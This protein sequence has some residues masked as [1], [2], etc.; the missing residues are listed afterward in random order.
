MRYGSQH[1][2]KYKAS[3]QCVASADVTQGEVNAEGDA[4]FSAV[5][6]F[7][8]AKL[9]IL[10]LFRASLSAEAFKR[11]HTMNGNTAHLRVRCRGAGEVPSLFKTAGTV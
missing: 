7:H 4:S 6:R 11:A 8:L 9:A 1:A 3:S 2:G 10:R 5:F